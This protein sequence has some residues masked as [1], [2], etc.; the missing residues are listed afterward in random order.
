MRH[1]LDMQLV[2]HQNH[3]CASTLQACSLHARLDL[4]LDVIQADPCTLKCFLESLIEGEKIVY[5]QSSL[6]DLLNLM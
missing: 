5:H 2:K 6:L 3:L 4:M 1:H